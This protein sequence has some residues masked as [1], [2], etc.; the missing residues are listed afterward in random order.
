MIK[1]GHLVE[2]EFL[3]IIGPDPL[4]SIDRALLERWVD[5][6]AGDLLR[7]HADALHNFTGE[8]TKAEFDTLEVVHLA[9]GFAKPATHLTVRIATWYS[10]DVV[11]LQEVIEE[12]QAATM[13]HPGVLHATAHAK[14]QRRAIDEGVV[15]AKIVVKRGMATFGG[16]V[17][18]GIDDLKAG[19]DLARSKSLDL[20]FVIRQRGH[21]LADEISAAEERVER[22]WPTRCLAP[23]DLRQRL[24]NGRRG[25]RCRRHARGRRARRFEKLASVNGCHVDPPLVPTT[26]TGSCCRGLMIGDVSSRTPAGRR[27]GAVPTAASQSAR[28]RRSRDARNNA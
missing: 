23:F 6:A 3:I 18:H 14:R 24:R 19:D 9:D 1:L 16:S 5:I 7:H 28:N 8:A 4:S 12:I 25:N 15:L 26:A 11:A 21:P 2:A 20:E 27:R 13:D 17:L 22:F 10:V